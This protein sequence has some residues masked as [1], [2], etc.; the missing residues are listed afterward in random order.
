MTVTENEAKLLPE[1]ADA[2]KK[3]C[4]QVKNRTG[5]LIFHDAPGGTGK[6]FLLNLVLDKVR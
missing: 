1:Q 4:D 2:Y 6:T 5:A 3:I